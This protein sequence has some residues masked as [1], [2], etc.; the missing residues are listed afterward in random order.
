MKREE[1]VYLKCLTWVIGKDDHLGVPLGSAS[2]Q[3]GGGSILVAT[4]LLAF[5]LGITF[6]AES[7]A[8]GLLSDRAPSA[9]RTIAV[10][11]GL[12]D[13]RGHTTWSY[14]DFLRF[15]NTLGSA[16]RIA[17]FSLLPVDIATPKGDRRLQAALVSL[18]YFSALGLQLPAGREFRCDATSCSEAVLS[19]H[20]AKDLGF[21]SSSG[22]GSPIRVDGK[23]FF[24]VG[25]AAQSDADLWLPIPSVTD[26][27]GRGFLDNGDIRWLA[28]ILRLQQ[29]DTLGQAR[30][31]I[32][33]LGDGVTLLTFQEA[34]L[35][36][37]LRVRGDIVQLLPGI[38]L[39]LSLGLVVL[40]SAFAGHFL[41]KDQA[42][43]W[44][45]SIV[46][47]AAAWA[48]GIIVAIT[49]AG[50]L[51]TFLASFRVHLSR[52]PILP[53]LQFVLLS[54]ILVAV[55]LH[56]SRGRKR[57]VERAGPGW[58]FRLM[59]NRY[60]L[61]STVVVL[62]AVCYASNG[63]WSPD[64]WDHTAVV[65]ALASNPL[66]PPH[67][68]FNID[69]PHPFE[70]PYALLEAVVVRITKSSPADVRTVFGLLNIVLW[71]AALRWFVRSVRAGK[72]A[73]FYV[74]LCTLVLWGYNAWS[75]SGFLHLNALG[76]VMTYPSTFATGMAL[77]S[78]AAFLSLV[79]RSPP[80]ILVL[81]PVLA[82]IL[83]SHPISAVSLYVGLIALWFAYCRH[84]P[85]YVLAVLAVTFSISF[86]L[87]CAW[88][89]FSIK[90]L[91]FQSA[92]Y[93]AAEVGMYP[94]ISGLVSKTL[95]ALFGF[96]ILI[97]RM[98]HNPRDFAG[99]M[100]LGLLII[101][102]TG[103][104]TAQYYLCRVLPFL[105][106]ML[107]F[108]LADWVARIEDLPSAARGRRA[109]ALYAGFACLVIVSSVTV[110]PGI[111]AS[112]PIF[113]HS[114]GQY[115]FLA[116][117]TRPS[118]VIISDPNTSLKI[119]VFGGKV[120]VYP[121]PVSFVNDQAARQE[122]VRQFLEPRTADDD[123]LAIVRHYNVKYIL[124]NKTEL[125]HWPEVLRSVL[126]FS[127]LA[128]SDTDL[129]LLR[130]TRETA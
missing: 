11:P 42:R 60:F 41:K 9:R 110:F 90:D 65:R 52:S 126:R 47:P 45:V 80:A 96:P 89:F 116:S 55:V 26:L 103:A 129:L 49:L 71:L 109:Q 4:G 2:S 34:N 101:Y 46:I 50:A 70:S 17:A 25:I 97:Q 123:R 122:S 30:R 14:A 119:P 32:G 111:M 68:V 81:S 108:A 54:L 63:L 51:Q 21:Q 43:W 120:V 128:Y 58:K 113:Q 5:C 102:S 56:F 82:L 44:Q 124:L 127:K 19:D 77:L 38:V 1:L 86:L 75:T 99:W 93:N 22:L 39:V 20:L 61:L 115:H 62:L 79:K 31:L 23:L 18:G 15:R 57:L 72:H 35:L 83:L 24:A 95:P 3:P 85:F 53:S 36:R 91:L 33:E 125:E 92:A 78:F 98:R 37:T 59:E 10:L 106:L 7:L 74:L 105:V 64:F 8:P 66:H 48:G 112:V 40:A 76:Q 69:R 12:Q 84:R 6:V 114:A 28:I 13:S 27:V 73:D 67:P 130:V 104:V 87:A 117:Y 88:P 107:H 16:A 29:G 121:Q 94:G 118:D 100:F